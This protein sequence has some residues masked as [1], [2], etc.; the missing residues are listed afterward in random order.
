MFGPPAWSVYEPPGAGTRGH[1]LVRCAFLWH[2]AP[3]GRNRDSDR[4]E[5]PTSLR[6][7]DD[8]ARDNGA[9]YRRPGNGRRLGPSGFSPDH[10]PALWRRSQDPLTLGL[11]AAL[12]V[13]VALSA[14]Y[15]PA[16][17]A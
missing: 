8:P 10:E 9:G 7:L 2:R 16:Q 5:S 12:L 11:A 3:Q 15:L 13:L 6:H 4:P 17:R 14:A 1:R